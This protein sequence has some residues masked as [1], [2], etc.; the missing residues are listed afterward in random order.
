M[1]AMMNQTT[2]AVIQKH[3]MMEFGEG[4]RAVSVL[5]PEANTHEAPPP[6]LGHKGL[7]DDC[8]SAFAARL[9]FRVEGP[10]GS[11]KSALVSHIGVILGQPVWTMHLSGD[12]EPQDLI[13]TA[14]LASAA[15]GRYIGSGLLAAAVSGGICFLDD[16]QALPE[17]SMAVLHSVLDDSRLIT[18]VIA[19]FSLRVHPDFRF[20][21]ALNPSSSDS[22]WARSSASEAL[23]SRLRPCFKMGYPN[24]AH[25]AEILEARCAGVHAELLAAFRGWAADQSEVSPRA[26]IQ[27]VAFASSLARE[28]PRPLRGTEAEAL[29]ERAAEHILV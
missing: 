28:H 16:L 1:G 26:A 13:V 10:P 11:G 7:I 12:T 29:I 9:P 22:R 25:L 5:L 4:A 18:S 2:G 21:A 24:P 20:C 17:R 19:G 8:V 27:I 6:F 23:E 3:R 15:E 14:R